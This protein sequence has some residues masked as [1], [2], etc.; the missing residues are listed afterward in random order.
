MNPV[1]SR[2]VLALA[3]RFGF[4]SMHAYHIAFLATRLFD[5][6]ARLHKRGSQEK[7][8]LEA[9]ALLHDIGYFYL[10]QRA[11]QTQPVFDQ[12]RW[13]IRFFQQVR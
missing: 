13:I 6:T 3:R 8:W 10:S 1:R 12:K 7:E 4:E 11:S 9:A 2:S 5:Q